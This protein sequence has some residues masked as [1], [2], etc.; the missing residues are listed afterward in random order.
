MYYRYPEIL[1]VVFLHPTFPIYFKLLALFLLINPNISFNLTAFSRN[2]KKHMCK[3]SRIYLFQNTNIC[4]QQCG[5]MNGLSTDISRVKNFKHI[6]EGV[7][8]NKFDVCVFLD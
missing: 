3:H 2:F 1:T 5:F 4:E 6:Y 8:V 7:N